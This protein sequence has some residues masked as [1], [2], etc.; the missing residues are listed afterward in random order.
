MTLLESFTDAGMM[1]HGSGGRLLGMSYG[2]R[3][4]GRQ[5]MSAPFEASVTTG[6]SPAAAS[7][8]GR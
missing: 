3:V 2:L 6:K 5:A 8:G 1:L 4:D 7:R